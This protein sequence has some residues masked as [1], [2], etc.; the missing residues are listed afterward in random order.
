VLHFARHWPTEVA[1]AQA[2]HAWS[3]SAR[4]A[5]WRNGALSITAERGLREHMPD[6][7]EGSLNRVATLVR[8]GASQYPKS[9]QGIPGFTTM[10]DALAT[11]QALRVHLNGGVAG[12]L[13]SYPCREGA[14][15]MLSDPA[16]FP[17]VFGEQVIDGKVTVAFFA[18]FSTVVAV[19]SPPIQGLLS[20]R[21]RGVAD[22]HVV[23]WVLQADWCSWQSSQECR[24]SMVVLWCTGYPGRTS[25]RGLWGTGSTCL[26]CVPCLGSGWACIP[27]WTPEASTS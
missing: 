14:D 23:E 20:W 4:Y 8:S 6:G 12:P 3:R 17:Q 19:G 2:P 22:G 11:V 27:S 1:R 25:G 7:S 18:V 13:G 9:A 5:R 21:A 10:V 24:S 15:T 26:S 16:V